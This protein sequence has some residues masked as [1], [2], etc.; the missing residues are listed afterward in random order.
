MTKK[1]HVHLVDD[2]DAS[3]ASETMRFEVD[4]RTYEIDLSSRNAQKFRAEIAPYITHAR[5]VIT[6]G[7][8]RGRAGTGSGPPRGRART[9]PRGG[10]QPGGG[11]AAD[12]TESGMSVPGYGGGLPPRA[13]F[14]GATL[15]GHI[16][17]RDL[18]DEQ[19]PPS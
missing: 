12:A 17:G 14:G 16:A 18:G 19:H 1:I 4:G 2:L 10:A 7:R 6:P 11:Q 5:R 9:A 3:E 8:R 13:E 15:D